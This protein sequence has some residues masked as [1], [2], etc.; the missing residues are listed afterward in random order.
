M[1]AALEALAAGIFVL[2]IATG[3][4]TARG[5]YE[6]SQELQRANKAIEQLAQVEHARDELDRTANAQRTELNRLRKVRPIVCNASLEQL[7]VINDAAR[8]PLP[9]PAAR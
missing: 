5:W 7:R 2:A 3:G 1:S 9:A 6:D 8:G 4:W